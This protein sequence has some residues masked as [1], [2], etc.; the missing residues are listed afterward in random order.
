MLV[1][2][3]VAKVLQRA[4]GRRCVLRCQVVDYADLYQFNISIYESF[5]T[6]SQVYFWHKKMHHELSFTVQRYAL[7]LTPRKIKH[8]KSA[9]V[10]RVQ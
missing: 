1:P 9:V 3:S 2:S 8:C 5:Q 4:K 7:I 10:Q 6:M